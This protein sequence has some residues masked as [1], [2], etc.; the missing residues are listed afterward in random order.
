MIYGTVSCAAGRLEHI[1]ELLAF[2]EHDHEFKW[3]KSSSYI[4]KHLEFVTAIFECIK[5]HNLRFRCIAVNIS[6]MRHR[7][8]NQNDP[9]LG[10]EK[11]VFK[12]LLRYSK[13]Y[14]PGSVTYSVT[15]DAG[16]EK[17]F[18]T[19]D[20]KRMLN[21]RYRRDTG[22]DYEAFESVETVLSHE[23]R[24]VQAA[25]VL[26]GAVAWVWNKRYESESKSMELKKSLASHVAKLARLHPRDPIAKKLGV[27]AG[28]Y[29]TLGYRTYPPTTHFTI[30]EFELRKG[31]ERELKAI[32][33]A[34]LDAIVDR[35]SRF[36]D[37]PRLGYEIELRCAYCNDTVANKPLD[38]KF[39]AQ[40]ISAAYRPKCTECASP[41][42]VN[43]IPDPRHAPLLAALNSR[44]N[45]SNGSK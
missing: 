11:Y 2:P 22:L 38:P 21:A 7:E 17:R 19:A 30:W 10:L 26:S 36:G 37:L 39:D 31:Q 13:E 40:T 41:R 35:N 44:T 45:P 33:A 14:T 8:Y 1:R 43:L 29:L 6:H 32:S 18:P 15:L 24:L 34:Q 23:C 27:K 42:I 28:H 20:K 3:K 16:R 5:K 9:A 12:Q 25:D 4:Q